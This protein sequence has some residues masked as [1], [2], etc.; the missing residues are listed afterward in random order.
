MVYPH[1]WVLITRFQCEGRGSSTQQAI[2]RLSYNSTPFRQ[3]HTRPPH[4]RAQSCETSPYFPYFRCQFQVHIII[5]ASDQPS[6]NWRFQGGPP[7]V[8]DTKHKYITCSSGSSHLLEPLAGPGETADLLD[9]YKSTQLRNSWM[10]EKHRARSGER[11]HSFSM[12][13]PAVLS[14]DF[15]TVTYPEGLQT[16]SFGFL[17]RLHCR[18]R[19]TWTHWPL[20]IELNPQT[21]FPPQ[22]SRN[23]TESSNSLITR[24][25]PQ[26][27][28]PLPE[29]L[30]KSCL[31][32]ITKGTFDCFHRRK[33][34]GF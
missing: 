5:W 19:T 32:S 27:T 30:A 12:S 4:L 31:I 20:V 23:G 7:W 24:L 10:E 2:L 33:F 8:S 1:G 11:V 18:G 21:L 6:G 28:S 29:V 22:R 17:W 14:P 9:Y 16:L 25:D 13:P 26:A 34:Q 15:H 3:H